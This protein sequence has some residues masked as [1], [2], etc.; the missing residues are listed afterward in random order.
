MEWFY[1][2]VIQKWLKLLHS[3]INSK[4]FEQC[5]NWIHIGTYFIWYLRA[6]LLYAWKIKNNLSW[7]NLL[8]WYILEN[9]TLDS[10]AISYAPSISK[11]YNNEVRRIISTIL[12]TVYFN[13]KYRIQVYKYR[14]IVPGSLATKSAE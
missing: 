6:W 13:I 5:R 9:L 2:S 10:H 8:P 3:F 14:C 4:M 7:T 12:P 11:S 1:Y